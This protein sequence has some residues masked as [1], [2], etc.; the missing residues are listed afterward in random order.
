MFDVIVG[1]AE[2]KD[3]P[4]IFCSYFFTESDL[5]RELQ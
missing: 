3:Q 1:P 5:N 4:Y 2:L